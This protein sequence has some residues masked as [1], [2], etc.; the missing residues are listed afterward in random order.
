MKRFLII[1]TS[2]WI[3]WAGR[4]ATSQEL[5]FPQLFQTG[6][7]EEKVG[8][9]PAGWQVVQGQ[10]QVG[11]DNGQRVLRQANPLLF[12]AALATLEWADYGVE[13]DFRCAAGA[14]PWGVGLVGYWQDRGHH[15]R[16]CIVNNALHL[17]KVEG[18]R[19]TS[20]T[21]FRQEF[22]RATWYHAR[23]TLRTTPQF[24]ELRGEVRPAGAEQPRAVL[25]YKDAQPGRL[26]RGRVGL[27]TG[28]ADGAFRNLT[29]TSLDPPLS[30]LYEETFQTTPKGH[31]P[32]H[33]TTWGGHWVSDVVD[34]QPAYRQMRDETDL[35][36]DDNAL[37]VLEWRDYQ[38]Y[39]RL[40][41][42]PQGETWGLGAV[43]Y[44]RDDRN[45]YR[46]RFLRGQLRLSKRQNGKDV[47][48]ADIP[49][50]MAAGGWYHLR[51][52]LEESQEG[53]WLRGKVWADEAEPA[54]WTIRAEDRNQPLP[55]GAV[56][57]LTFLTAASFDDLKVTYNQPRLP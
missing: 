51:F 13:A 21:Q 57:F 49:F 1:A 46:L 44:F 34:G 28:H 54:A 4:A 31:S 45:H 3:L 41:A 19:V 38:L 6:F 22:A 52:G 43:G 37:A 26:R 25:E 27:W 10:W 16:C 30:P 8:R 2:L 29:V 53:V 9:L 39:T 11:Q 5:L 48:L 35:S 7:D 56:G 23:F 47:E 14:G 18:G 33:W 17:V 40:K 12:D 55:G 20:L 24:V 32:A 42:E 36:F 15:Y 50:R